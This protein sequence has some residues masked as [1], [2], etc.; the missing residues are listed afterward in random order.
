MTGRTPCGV[1]PVCHCAGI[2]GVR[3][4]RCY[5]R[6]VIGVKRLNLT[7]AD[8][9][10][11]SPYNTY[12]YKGL[13]EGPICNP[14]KDAIEAALYP[15]ESYLKGYLYFCLG[16]PEAGETVFSKTLEEHNANVEKY[17]P[18]WIEADKKNNTAQ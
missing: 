9:A 18:L 3:C 17:R 4:G 1:R 15:D 16:D 12:K 11:D 8:L 2:G 13:P 6:Y 5:N 14:G 10:T 7:N